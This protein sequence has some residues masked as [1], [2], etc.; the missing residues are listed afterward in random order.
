MKM[1]MRILVVEDNAANLEL[2]TYLLRAAGHDVRLAE[3]GV[4]GLEI[5]RHADLDVVITDLQMPIMD[6][7][8]LLSELRGDPLLFGILVIAVTAFCK[9]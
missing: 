2:V 6:G 4:Q 1:P 8:K 9:R 7:F 3:N 5:A